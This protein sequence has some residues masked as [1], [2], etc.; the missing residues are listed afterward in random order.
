MKHCSILL[1]FLLFIN[2]V[3]SQEDQI[4]LL[5]D[6]TKD[7][8]FDMWAL[9][10]FA[11][12]NLK[13]DSELARFFYYWIGSNVKYDYEFFDKMITGNYEY[14]EYVQKQEAY[15]VYEDRQGVCAG[16]ANLF[17]WFMQDVDI[18][19]EYIGGH[20][21]DE[22]N[23]YVELHADDNFR[24]AWSAI[25]L[26]GKW[27]LVDATWGTSLNKESSD[28]YFDMP[29]ERAIIT[30]FPEKSDWQ[31]LEKPLTLDEFNNSKFIK[32]IWFKSGFSDIPK[33][34]M[35]SQYYYFVFRSNP[36]TSILVNLLYS[37]NNKEF[38]KLRE[39]NKI[40]QGDYTILRFYKSIIP[41]KTF[42][43]VNLYKL[44]GEADY[45]LWYSD[46]INFKI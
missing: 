41:K 25:K 30:H 3:S 37:V 1:F 36:D 35:D 18:D 20:I 38:H 19:V 29:P 34:K 10:E 31:L 33:V 23:H 46:V 6:K 13:H 15:R 32:P 45:A 8:N 7:S 2:S 9:S 16:Y 5:V 28:Y 17:S 4:K 12:K 21:R 24:H 27:V 39:M 40:V 14:H 11:Q 26:D 42:F 44:W 22:R 43:K